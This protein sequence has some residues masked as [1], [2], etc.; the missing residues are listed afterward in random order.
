MTVWFELTKDS[1]TDVTNGVA[2][3]LELTSAGD[4]TQATTGGLRVA[5]DVMFSTVIILFLADGADNSAGG[6]KKS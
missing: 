2:G 3:E 5:G 6:A 4:I 1:A